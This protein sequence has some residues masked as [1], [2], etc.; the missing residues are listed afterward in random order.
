MKWKSSVKGEVE[1]GY[2]TTDVEI[3]VDVDEMG[4]HVL[5][6]TYQENEKYASSSASTELYLGYH[7]YVHCP[8]I[9]IY[10]S[11]LSNL[12]LE[13]TLICNNKL[14]DGVHGKFKI[15]K[16]TVSDNLAVEDGYVE[17]PYDGTSLSSVKS[18]PLYLFKT[19]G[20]VTRNINPGESNQ[21]EI[22]VMDINSEYTALTVEV[23]TIFC[24]DNTNILL[25]ARVYKLLHSS[26]VDESDI[27]KG[28]S[29]TFY[30]ATPGEES[31]VE[32]RVLMGTVEITA[33]GYAYLT[34]NCDISKGVYTVLACYEPAEW[35]SLYDSQTWAAGTLY[36]NPDLLR[37]SITTSQTF[38]YNEGDTV[39]A[40]FNSDSSLTGTVS[41][42]IDEQL[43]TSMT[44]K[45][46]I[47]L[48][49]TWTIGEKETTEQLW[50]YP[51]SHYMVVRY[52]TTDGYTWDYPFL[53]WIRYDTL[54]R[55]DHSMGY[56][57]A[58]EEPISRQPN[59]FD[60][61]VRN[62]NLTTSEHEEL[63]DTGELNIT[64]R[65][66]RPL[67]T[68]NESEFIWSEGEEVSFTF[69]SDIALTGTIT[70]LFDDTEVYTGTVT[71]RNK[72]TPSFTIPDEG[73]CVTAGE[74]T[75]IIRYI[76][77]EGNSYDYNYTY[78]I[79]Y[80][81]S[82]EYGRFYEEGEPVTVTTRTGA[83][84]LASEP[85]TAIVT[86]IDDETIT[87]EG[88]VNI[89]MSH[90][91]IKATPQIT[92]VSTPSIVTAGT[93]TSISFTSDPEITGTITLS[94]DGA[95]VGSTIVEDSSAF[96]C[97]CL[98]PENYTAGTYTLTMSLVDSDG[99][100]FNYTFKLQL[101][102]TTSINY[103]NLHGATRMDI[104]L[105]SFD[106]W[107]SIADY[108][109]YVLG[110][111]DG[112]Y[113]YSG[114]YCFTYY[115]YGLSGSE[116]WTVEMTVSTSVTVRYMLFILA[117]IE[118]TATDYSLQSY[119]TILELRKDMSSIT[120]CDTSCDIDIQEDTDYTITITSDGVGNVT[121][122]ISDGANTQTVIME[123][124][125]DS[126]TY[127]YVGTR[128]WGVGEITVKNYNITVDSDDS[129]EVRYLSTTEAGV[130]D[131]SVD[132]VE[133]ES[134]KTSGLVNLT[135]K[136]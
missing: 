38:I 133:D 49:F 16:N 107:N 130:M 51:G 55:L 121:A 122:S 124:V 2:S 71:S 17:Y 131:V 135:I 113:V 46:T 114:R 56:N 103:S 48:S 136:K 23:P 65:R 64:I 14:V 104:D 87:P 91:D 9:Y 25:V 109:S 99:E 27:P 83:R 40:L 128:K 90:V 73:D 13:A 29:I 37:P 11:Q 70:I 66:S 72:V 54:T 18:T 81:T 117:T 50:C 78:T 80:D 129:N 15:N 61:Y 76:D 74:H 125:L 5:I 127:Y 85:F 134:I 59:P 41:L 28:G 126:D 33:S 39:E 24:S 1:D 112:Q 35:S 119:N 108:N 82:L 120:L 10:K 31:A 89:S 3:P 57:D 118:D 123:D 116:Y 100:E 34:C 86:N 47:S 69:R 12:I 105:T 8:P 77:S 96:S 79:Q 62:V 30:I 32:N 20:A 7:T 26:V 110:S 97:D 132:V 63:V 102:Y 60:V 42:L 21:A 36:Y 45:N 43:V 68:V 53:F 19:A 67:L 101:R 52:E 93:T 84:Y 106:D 4:E 44:V 94:M 111:S 22:Y 6:A 88:D 75:L 115:D 92:A 58:F 95:I 98:I